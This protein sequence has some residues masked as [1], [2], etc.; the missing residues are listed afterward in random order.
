M[1]GMQRK[2]PGAQ[3]TGMH[4]LYM[5]IAGTAQRSYAPNHRIYGSDNKKRAGLAT[6]P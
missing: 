6:S 1:V 4:F 3:H 2:A 5:R